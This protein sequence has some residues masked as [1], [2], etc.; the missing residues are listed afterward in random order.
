[1]CFSSKPKIPKALPP[2]EAQMPDSQAA[3]TLRKN[4]ASGGRG[5]GTLL[6][7]TGGVPAG[8][9]NTGGA[10]LLGG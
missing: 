8:S 2:Q 7:G 4:A 6:T 10:T 1:M 5:T 3:A 9:L